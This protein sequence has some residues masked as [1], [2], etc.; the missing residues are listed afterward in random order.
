MGMWNVFDICC[1]LYGELLKYVESSSYLRRWST[2]TATKVLSHELIFPVF[3]VL[4]TTWSIVHIPCCTFLHSL[5][6]K[7]RQQFF[8]TGHALPFYT[9]FAFFWK[10][11]TLLEIDAIP[12]K[13]G[14]NIVF[15]SLFSPEV[16]I[17]VYLITFY[18]QY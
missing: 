3:F 7:I 9:P 5:C 15:F 12:W 2:E 18:S 11:Q 17:L 6:L 1:V 10:K 4:S 13:K 16:L 14:Q 8:S